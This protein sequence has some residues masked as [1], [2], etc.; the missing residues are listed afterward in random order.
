MKIDNL[1]I[2]YL[3]AMKEKQEAIFC[4]KYEKAAIARDKERIKSKEIFNI[5]IP[6][7]EFID[8]NTC[9]KIIDDYCKQ[10][11][12]CSIYDYSLC[13]KNINRQIKLKDLG[14]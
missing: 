8:W 13:L 9:D 5:L 6:D 2:E 12:N 4:Q 1:I 14:I 7:G 11:Y 3:K 10:V